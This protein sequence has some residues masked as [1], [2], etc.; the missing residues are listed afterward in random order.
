MTSNPNHASSPR[1]GIRR[2]FVSFADSRMYRSIARISGQAAALGVFDRIAV[3][4]E[5]SLDPAFRQRFA[6]HLVRGSRGYGY[7]CWKPQVILQE[8]DGMQDGDLLQYTDTG[9][10]LRPQ[11]RMRLEEYF[12]SVA[13]HPSGLLGFQNRPWRGGSAELAFQLPD[14]HWIKGDL[15]DYFQIRDRPDITDTGTF[16]A[17]IIFA[18]KCPNAVSFFRQWLA[19]FEHDFTLVDD[20]PSRT[21]NLPGFKE[22]RHDQGVFSILAK[23]YGIA[24]ESAFEYWY[25]KSENPIEPDWTAIV[26]RPI[27]AIRDKDL[28]MAD[29]LAKMPRR[30]VSTIARTLRQRLRPRKCCP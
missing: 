17:G 10:H 6:Q 11:G 8:L 28:G 27:W 24:S 22:H 19:V 25:P 23:K 7:W 9:C 2:H 14:K 12:T 3:L 26:D 4:D 18:R 30:I 29:K 13:A 1:T 20:T 16:G 15:L 21:P 5:T